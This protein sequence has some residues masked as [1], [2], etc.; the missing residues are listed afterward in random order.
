[1]RQGLSLV[2][3]HFESPGLVEMQSFR[4]RKLMNRLQEYSQFYQSKF[5][6]AGIS[7]SDVKTV[8]DIKYLPFTEKDE[9]RQEEA[10]ALRAAP[11]EEIVRIHSTSGTTGKPVIVPYTQQDVEDWADM[12]QRC[13]SIAGLT[14]HD[15]V[16]ITPGYGLWTAGVGF[17]NGCERLGA[18]AIPMGP[19]N[20]EKQLA[21][22]VDLQA[23]ALIGTAS[24]ALLLAEEINK[25]DLKEQVKLKKAVLGSERW[26]EKMRTRLEELLGVESYDIY[27]LTEV[28]GPGIGIDCDYHDGIHYFPEYLYF[29]IIDPETG[30]VLPPGQ[31]GELVITTLVK[32]GMPLVR[33]RTHDLTYIKAEPC[34]C[35]LPYP[36]TGRI[37]GR[38]DDTVKI[39]GIN[40]YPGQIEDVIRMSPGLSSEYQM[41]IEREAGKDNVLIKVEADP[42]HPY[43]HAAREFQYNI[44][45]IIN[46][47]ADVD[48]VPYQDL[49]RSEK[50][51]KRVFDRRNLD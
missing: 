3:E 40:V 6:K 42:L 49:P 20:T 24:Y 10:L 41:I 15:R 51:T 44:K 21:M 26:G 1:M 25:R 32:E 11:E 34:K 14:N 37:L 27:G 16:Q 36:Q 22:M 5:N 28:Y 30:K 8:D 31:L 47:I 7:F 46:I 45:A 4:L 18:M 29:E 12:M 50:K 38:S 48:V 35:G 2:N 43:E 13:L 19:G 9:L 17:Q 33:Y 23:T 39:K